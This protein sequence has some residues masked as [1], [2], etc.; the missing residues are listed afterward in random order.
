MA[1]VYIVSEHNPDSCVLLRYN[2]F[3]LPHGT[4][5]DGNVPPHML[6]GCMGSC[7]LLAVLSFTQG[8]SWPWQIIRKCVCVCVEGG[9]SGIQHVG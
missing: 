3:T 6:V 2:V 4:F 1:C 8:I 9:S 5:Q 7:H